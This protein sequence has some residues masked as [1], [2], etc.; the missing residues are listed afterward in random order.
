MNWRKGLLRLW[1]V[2]TAIWIATVIVFGLRHADDS[3]F[4][5]VAQGVWAAELYTEYWYYRIIRPDVAAEAR[6]VHSVFDDPMSSRR[7][8]SYRERERDEAQLA[9]D[10]AE[11]AKQPPKPPSP[12]GTRALTNADLD[13]LWM[14]PE[15]SAKVANA[16]DELGEIWALP[17]AVEK[18]GWVLDALLSFAFWLFGPPIA[19]LVV[20]TSLIWAFGWAFRGFRAQVKPELQ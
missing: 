9:K 1:V 14:A 3:V 15:C 6:R 18:G 2:G 19:A 11:E 17:D 4:E 13:R 5:G 10:E 8:V 16:K 20:G 7:C 12:D